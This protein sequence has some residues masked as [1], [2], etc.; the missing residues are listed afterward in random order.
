MRLCHY[1]SSLHFFVPFENFYTEH[2][3]DFLHQ[4]VVLTPKHSN[5]KH[6]HGLKSLTIVTLSSTETAKFMTLSL[7]RNTSQVGIVG[8][9]INSSSPLGASQCLFS[10]I[11]NKFANCVAFH[12]CMHTLSQ[13]CSYTQDKTSCSEIST[14]STRQS[15][16]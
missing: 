13:I 14:L 5:R 4:H 11:D 3:C 15:V 9:Q 10:K 6:E 2:S 16:C 8:A 12:I 7:F 1:I